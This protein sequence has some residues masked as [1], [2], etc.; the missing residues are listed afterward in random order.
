MSF[1]NHKEEKIYGQYGT[2]FIETLKFTSAVH[3]RNGLSVPTSVL[4]SMIQKSVSFVSI[5]NNTT[6]MRSQ[7]GREM[8]VYLQVERFL[9]W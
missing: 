3:K 9:H 5:A 4:S 1:K 2:V 6:K 8:P 7:S